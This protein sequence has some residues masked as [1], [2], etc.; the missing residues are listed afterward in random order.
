MDKKQL[1]DLTVKQIGLYLNLLNI[2]KEHCFVIAIDKGIESKNFLVS[3]DDKN[4]FKYILKVYSESDIEE[5]K[6][7][8]EI[9]RKLDS[10]TKKKFFPV[11]VKRTFYIN[12][13]P[14]ILLKYIPGRI[15]SKKDISPRL[16]KKIAKKHA[17]MHYLFFHFNPR[18]KKSRFSIFDFSF[19]DLYVRNKKSPY[20]K[21]LHDAIIIL[22][23]ESKLFAKVNFK[24]SIIHEDLNIENIIVTDN[25]DV[26]FIDFGESHRAEII[27]D[28]AIAIKEIIITNRGVNINLIQDYL[29]SY[30]KV[31][32][33]NK[34]E[35]GA[36]PFLIRR[37]TVFMLA[38]LLNKQE[39]NKDINL[40]GKI[41]IEASVLR[42]L[43]KDNYLIEN[44]IKKYE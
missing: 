40:R 44:F 5:L 31:T 22:R 39:T 8:E 24:K 13:K 18:H 32:P 16:I 9:L 41:E 11:I 34:D 4:N 25:G 19:V 1:K 7:E 37:R 36:L 12:Y 6:Y 3:V 14:S 38:Y 15:L 17:E 26:N 30:Q 29:D 27:S 10:V 35:I 42:S 28:I 43:Q 33:I 20:Y 2:I 21:I 23:Q